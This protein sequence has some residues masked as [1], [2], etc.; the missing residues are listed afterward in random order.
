MSA[1]LA[2]PHDVRN[3]RLTLSDGVVQLRKIIMI[4][5]GPSE[6][7]NPW[8]NAG[9]ETEPFGL[10][11]AAKRAAIRRSLEAHFLRLKRAGRA[12]LEGITFNDDGEGE[13]EVYVKW[14]D[15]V[16]G[17]EEDAQIILPFGSL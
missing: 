17:A 8:N 1:G 12:R 2:M 5:A 11:D 15:L 3:G 14:R 9:S 6:N 10:G 16:R 13:L 4:A 7:K